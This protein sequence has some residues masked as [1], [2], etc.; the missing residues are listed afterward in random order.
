MVFLALFWALLMA[1]ITTGTIKTTNSTVIQEQIQFGEAVDA[2]EVVFLHTGGTYMLADCTDTAK[3][4]IAGIAV[5]GNASS[6]YGNIA[7]GGTIDLGATLTVGERYYLSTGGN[8]MPSG[9]LT[10]GDYVSL[11]GIATSTSLLQ[12]SFINAG[13]QVP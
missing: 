4:E 7:T 1:D 2:G 8:I 3:D 9:D 5:T 6:A 10:T 12:L 13:V 11:L